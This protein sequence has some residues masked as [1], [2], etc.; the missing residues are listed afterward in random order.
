MLVIPLMV[1]QFLNAFEARRLVNAS[2]F[3]K[4]ALDGEKLSRVIYNAVTNTR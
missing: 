2:V 1:D 4:S 3:Q